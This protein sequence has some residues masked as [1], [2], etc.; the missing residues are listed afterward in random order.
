MHRTDRSEPIRPRR[1]GVP[2]GPHSTGSHPDDYHLS[3]RYRDRIRRGRVQLVHPAE[4][5]LRRVLQASLDQS[6]NSGLIVHLRAA[7]SAYRTPATPD[8]VVHMGWGPLVA[9]VLHDM[10]RAA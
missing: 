1:R 6:P 9:R 2:V 7:E 8:P 5:D 3:G 10:R 4:P